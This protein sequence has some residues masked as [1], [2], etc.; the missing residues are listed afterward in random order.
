MGNNLFETR[1][2]SEWSGL[3]SGWLSTLKRLTCSKTKLKHGT[4]T[5]LTDF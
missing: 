3:Y 1:Y 5:D 4:T 2:M